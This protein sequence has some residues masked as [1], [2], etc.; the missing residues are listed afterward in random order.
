MKKRNL[1]PI[2]LCLVFLLIASGVLS[3]EPDNRTAKL[4]QIAKQASTP[5]QLSSEKDISYDYLLAEYDFENMA[6]E[7]DFQGW[8]SEDVTEQ[9][10]TYFHVDDFAGIT[11][12]YTPLSGGQSL[13]CGSR[14]DSET[15]P[16]FQL[17]A[18]MHST[19]F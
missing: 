14:G 2:I 19:R 13:W 15:L 18:K 7:P 9:A 8:T 3:L 6:G 12:D 17:P 16:A 1:T 10:G 5:A 4:P 11:P